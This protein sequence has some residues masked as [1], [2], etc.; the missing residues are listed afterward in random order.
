MQKSISVP[1]HPLQFSTSRCGTSG[2]VV[3]VSIKR[4]TYV[5]PKKSRKQHAL[6]QRVLR[7]TYF[8]IILQNDRRE[9]F[10]F[11]NDWWEPEQDLNG[12]IVCLVLSKS[13]LT[14]TRSG[15]ECSSGTRIIWFGFVHDEPARLHRAERQS[16][17]SFLFSQHHNCTGCLRVASGRPNYA[18]KITS[19][20]QIKVFL[21]GGS[22]FENSL[23][24][25]QKKALISFCFGSFVYSAGCPGLFVPEPQRLH[26]LPNV[27]HSSGIR[28]SSTFMCLYQFD[29]VKKHQKSPSSISHKLGI[30][31]SVSFCHAI[32]VE[33]Y[34]RKS[35]CVNCV[36]ITQFGPNA[37]FFASGVLIVI[38]AF[39]GKISL[40]TDWGTC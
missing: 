21:H 20:H 35:Q 8:P 24:C 6:V 3:V 16:F 4:S 22:W 36:W 15:E 17:L 14:C 30:E 34:K 25:Q 1:S 40:V 19:F 28:L 18:S 33:E 31:S 12:S 37:S 26:G 23:G 11:A 39:K 32:H 9:I 27:A 7:L 2:I 13:R 10:T 38:N 5:V 29:A